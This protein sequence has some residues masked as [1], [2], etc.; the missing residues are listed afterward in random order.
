MNALAELVADIF[1]DN[2]PL[3][4]RSIGARHLGDPKVARAMSLSSHYRGACRKVQRRATAPP[5][6]GKVEA[7]AVDETAGAPG[8]TTFKAIESSSEFTGRIVAEQPRRRPLRGQ[9]RR[10]ILALL[11]G[12]CSRAELDTACAAANSPSTVHK[13][14]A[15]GL[16][17]ET[18]EGHGTNRFGAPVAFAVYSLPEDQ[19]RQA[20]A[21]LGEGNDTSEA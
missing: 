5:G 6:P 7:P 20:L 18:D 3:V 9:L 17:I 16:R 1:D 8:E 14:R 2:L 10:A 12:P 4:I 21:L 19:R 15:R 11:A 13:L